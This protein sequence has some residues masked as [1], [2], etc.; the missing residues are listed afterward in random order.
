MALPP[1]ASRKAVTWCLPR[2]LVYLWKLPFVDPRRIAV[3]GSSQGGG[4]VASKLA[5]THAVSFFAISDELK[6][7][8]AVA[9]YPLCGFATQQLTPMLRSVRF[10]K[11]TISWRLNWPNR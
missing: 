10:W 3:M 7:K 8:A 1:V 9:Y 6:F 5:S 4:I 11:R 2:A